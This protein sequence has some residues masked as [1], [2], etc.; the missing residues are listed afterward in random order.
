[1]KFLILYFLIILGAA[2]QEVAPVPKEFNY[3]IGFFGMSAAQRARII[4]AA[5]IAIE[6]LQTNEFRDRILNHRFWLKKRFATNNGLSNAQVYQKLVEGAELWNAQVNGSID[7]LCGLYDPAL[8]KNLDELT[9]AYTHLHRRQVYFNPDR[10]DELTDVELAGVLVHE[11]IHQLG[12]EH[13]DTLNFRQ[14][15]SVPYAVES[16]INDLGKELNLAQK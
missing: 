6:I 14:H 11:W 9:L 15:K 7:L 10:F 5:D 16:I 3:H 8:K 12:F 1:L 13:N 2:A 4:H